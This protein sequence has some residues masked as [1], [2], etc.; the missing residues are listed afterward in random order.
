MLRW[1]ILGAARIA[2]EWMAPAIHAS[3][4]GR[5]TAI[6]S[7]TPG[8][9]AGVVRGMEGVRLH[10]SYEAL[11]SD[12]EV[13]AVYVALPNSAHVRW[14]LA[15]VA[16]GKHVLCEKPVA[17]SAAGIDRL[18][19]AR[20]A[21]GLVVAEAHKMPHDRQWQRAREIVAE[22][23]IGELRQVSGGFTFQGPADD[24]RNSAALGGGAL[25]DLAAYP[26]LGARLV[27]GEEPSSAVA[28][29]DMEGGVDTT[30][31]ACLRFPG[32]ALDF[33]VSMRMALYQRMT[34]LGTEGWLAM[35]APFN[36]GAYAEG[37]LELC[38]GRER[39]VIERFPRLDP[40]LAQAE[41]FAASVLD[42]APFP[43]PLEES[44]ATQTVIDLIAASCG[45]SD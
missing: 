7:R 40:Y 28:R 11:L 10:D 30:T 34:F 15:A 22:G 31:R 12:R 13:D 35:T 41:A 39:R 33:L 18:I 9:A 2:R 25:R 5:V 20:D 32:F 42:G 21:S 19:A 6:A 17:L 36:P 43:F 37:T 45:P 23:G 44:R 27:S 29:M 1:G 8:K 3:R 26:C 38:T 24:I 4:R 14:T 16:A